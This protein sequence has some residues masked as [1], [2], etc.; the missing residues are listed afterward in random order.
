M[1]MAE[2]LVG[3]FVLVGLVSWQQIAWVM[4]DVMSH[5]QRQEV[6]DV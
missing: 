3:L 5:A 6:Y 2:S 4:E 1:I